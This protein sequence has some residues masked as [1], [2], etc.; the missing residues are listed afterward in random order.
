MS[1]DIARTNDTA[2]LAKF[3]A[4]SLKYYED[5]FIQFFARQSL[6]E[7]DHADE[8]FS[9]RT[10]K[11]D[12]PLSP[13]AMSP[14]IN[15]GHYARVSIVRACLK[16]FIC[17]KGGKQV[18]S[19]GAGY[20]TSYFYLKSIGIECEKYVEIDVPEVIQKKA[21]VIM[22]YRAK[23]FE[24]YLPELKYHQERGIMSK[25]YYTLPAD[26]RSPDAVFECLLQDFG[27][28]KHAPTLFLSE[29][30]LIYMEAEEGDRLVSRIPELFSR[31]YFVLYEQIRPNDR[32]GRMMVKNIEILGCPL[33]SLHIY[34]S[35]EDLIDRFKK[36]GW[37]EVRAEDMNTVYE[38]VIVANE[39][40]RRRI[41]KLEILD[42]LEEWVMMNQHYCLV[43]ASCV[44]ED[45]TAILFEELKKWVG[46]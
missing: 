33:R 42:E 44:S 2:T 15:R 9:P 37:K 28:E 32:F 24:K 30:V 23:Q 18:I 21:S 26:L 16:E 22:K 8:G 1:D 6:S 34:A 14:L 25:H 45:D 5:P 29:C 11:G 3:S 13:R 35:L 4:V 31:A 46:S 39:D 20:D 38:E 7:Q 43:I 27:L 19:F 36:N 17:K 41:Q 40:E 12:G 10:R